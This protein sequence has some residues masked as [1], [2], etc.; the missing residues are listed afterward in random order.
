MRSQ[1][2]VDSGDALTLGIGTMNLARIRHFFASMVA[3][4]LYSAVEIDPAQV[5]TLQFVNKGVG[6]DLKRRLTGRSTGKR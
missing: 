5:A 1:G 4:G 3:V 2:I 6:L